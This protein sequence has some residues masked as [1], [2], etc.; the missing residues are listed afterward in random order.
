M[1]KTTFAT[2]N[3]LTRKAWEERLFRDTVKESYFERFMGSDSSSIV[4]VN[5]QLEKG[6]G[7]KVTFGIRKRLSGAGVTGDQILEGNEE[8]LNT[9][10]YSLSLEMYRHAVRDA[11]GLTRQRAMFSISSESEM[12]L[13]DWGAEKIDSLLFKALLED[14]DPTRVA[15]L[16]NT[17]VANYT[18]TS[19]AATAF[20]ALTANSLLEPYFISYVKTLA[21]T[22]FDRDIVPIRPVKIKGKEYFVLLVHPD[23]M[24]NLKTN[25][26]FQQA[27]REAEVR[28]SENPLFK[29]ATAIWDGVVV[30][31]HENVPIGTDAGGGSNIPYAKCAL[32]GAQSLC[33]AWGKRPEIV[34]DDF[35]YG[36]QKGSAWCMIGKAG[37][38]TFESETYGSIGV[39]LGR[40]QVSDS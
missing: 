22:G 9:H 23:V 4:Q 33:W 18:K 29:G 25:S 26:V 19:T 36:N 2:D 12:A 10:D 30:H 21:K 28:G 38:P 40:T 31:E 34:Q 1:A 16:T 5:T 8:A 37:R 39:Y 20:S 32:L 7:D 3:A 11:G 6:Q 15:Y 17:G 27:M 35:D 24:F 14:V 13:R